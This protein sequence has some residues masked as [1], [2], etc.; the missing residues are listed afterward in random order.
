M[1]R[2][3]PPSDDNT[4]EAPPPYTE[5]AAVPPGSSQQQ[6]P[7][8]SNARLYTTRAQ[9]AVPTGS[10]SASSSS[11]STHVARPPARPQ[12]VELVLPHVADFL[13]HV[14]QGGPANNKRPRPLSPQR[15]ELYLV[16]QGAVPLDQDWRLSG[17]EY[18]E[19]SGTHVD[20]IEVAV[21]AGAASLG[22]KK[23][24]N[25]DEGVKRAAC[26][27]ASRSMDLDSRW[28][29]WADEEQARW[30]AERLR[31]ELASSPSCCVD[32]PRLR[33][34]AERVNAEVRAE[35]TAFRRE[36][37]MGLWDSKSGWTIVVAATATA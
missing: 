5:H 9:D 21:G 19:Q 34:V 6:Q 4:N 1:D 8:A 3:E 13:H 14:A 32:A 24:P 12:L 16:P 11:T 23:H 7:L 35:E 20:V 28:C 30:L 29:W 2:Y 33:D 18:L 15:A 17:A 37:E 26:G 25:G 22:E 27:Y 10:R 36:N 31:R